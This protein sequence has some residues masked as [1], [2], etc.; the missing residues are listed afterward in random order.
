MQYSVGSFWN[1]L[2]AWL[3][4]SPLILLAACTAAIPVAPTTQPPSPTATAPVVGAVTA[5]SASPSPRP[6]PSPTIAPTAAASPS[7]SPTALPSLTPAPTP[8]TA[9]SPTPRASGI[10]AAAWVSPDDGWLAVDGQILGTSDAGSKWAKLSTTGADVRSLSFV[11]LDVGW[12]ATGSGL[13]YTRDGGKTWRSVSTSGATD[14]VRVDFA[15]ESHGWV[16]P[17][18]S[19]ATSQQSILRTTDGGKTWTSLITPC[20]SRFVSAAFSFYG[21]I[22]GWLACGGEP[23]AGSQAKYVYRTDDAGSH[24]RLVSQTSM[25][26]LDA[27]APKSLPTS[28]YVADVFFRDEASGWLATSRGGLLHT[29]DGGKSWK[30]LASLYGERFPSS[31]YF[32]SEERGYTLDAE[33]GQTVLLGTRDSG[34]T[35]RQLY[36]SR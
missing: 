7:A 18:P 10:T 11:N 27:S 8:T 17:K 1:W 6:R 29:T 12:A 23:S 4:L 34:K 30:P 16:L 14:L 22:S 5:P 15:D 31:P 13:Y 19:G 9:A 2:V 32:F 33:G 35:W 24:W 36:P 3:L 28:G 26:P 20:D 21:P 25:S